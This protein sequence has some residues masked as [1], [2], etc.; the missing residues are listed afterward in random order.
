MATKNIKIG[1]FR[2][3]RLIGKGA[4][5]DV[6]EGIHHNGQRAAIKVVTNA[7]AQRQDIMAQ[8]RNEAHAASKL[9]HPNII[10]L[11]DVGLIDE[12][13]SHASRG[14][15]APS[16]PYLIMELA[17]TFSLKDMMPC[18]HFDQ[19][20]HVARHV[21]RALAHAHARGVIH[22]DIKP[23]NILIE[24]GVER[25]T[26]K[27]SDFGISH[28]L[29]SRED[30]STRD[31]RLQGTP[32]YMAPEQIRG[33]WREQGPWTDLY[34][35]GCV[36]HRMVTGQLLR[37]G[38]LQQV[39]HSHLHDPLPRLRPLFPVPDHFELWLARMLDR[40]IERRYR[41]AA[42]ALA[43]LER[44][45]APLRPLP[46][47]S[48]LGRILEDED[49]PTS[50]SPAAPPHPEGTFGR[51]TSPTQRV[52]DHWQQQD[53]GR[54]SEPLRGIGLGLFG[55]KRSRTV[56]RVPQRDALWDAFKRTVATRRPHM[57]VLEGPSGI[58]KTHL[59]KWLAQRT[60][61]L[62]LSRALRASY[63]L[64][65][66]PLDG[67]PYALAKRY[68]LLGLPKKAIERSLERWMRTHHV[69]QQQ[70][71]GMAPVLTALWSTWSSP[72]DK[73]ATELLSPQQRNAALTQ[74]LTHMPARRAL[75]VHLDNV[76]WATQDLDILRRLLTDESTQVPILILATVD[77]DAAQGSCWE[78]LLEDLHEHPHVQTLD[79]E[80]MHDT[81]I[82]SL[83]RSLIGLEPTLERDIIARSKG[84]PVFTVEL[85]SEL[86]TSDALVQGP[87]GYK[88]RDPMGSLIPRDVEA[89]WLARVEH[90]IDALPGESQDNVWMALE[91]ASVMTGEFEISTWKMAAMQLAISI[92]N[93]LLDHLSH[94]GLLR[95]SNLSAHLSHPL[96]A[97][98]LCGHAR[99]HGRWE[100]LHSACA[101]ALDAQGGQDRRC[102]E[103]WLE[104]NE[105]EQALVPLQ[106]IMEAK[107]HRGMFHDM[108]QL[109]ETHQHILDQ[110]PY[111][112][113]AHTQQDFYRGLLIMETGRRSQAVAHFDKALERAREHGW[114]VMQSLILIQHALICLEAADPEQARDHL[115]QAMEAASHT[116]R[117]DIKVSILR[118]QAHINLTQGH[119]K[120]ALA[121]LKILIE[122]CKEDKTLARA[123]A[124]ALIDQSAVLATMGQHDR[125]DEAIELA[126]QISQEAGGPR[127]IARALTQRGELHRHAGRHQQAISDYEQALHM[128]A[129]SESPRISAPLHL[130]IAL[131]HLD[132]RQTQEAKHHLYASM[133]LAKRLNIQYIMP[134]V[135]LGLLICLMT[136]GRMERCVEL[137]TKIQRDFQDKRLTHPR[138]LRMLMVTAMA[139]AEDRDMLAIHEELSALYE[140]L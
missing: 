124:S 79:I 5:A 132:Q 21:L 7:Q 126:L 104:A 12:A 82:S 10:A 28:A 55:I 129:F 72:P 134:F 78:G 75:V 100:A 9:S 6:W 116:D 33:L 14:A 118:N 11:Y 46:P 49:E 60:A 140:T 133:D 2:L 68:S 109:V 43:D 45:H 65:H 77:S 38:T 64:D 130:N 99:K 119:P 61:E 52:P 53:Q 16:A 39:L 76:Q 47:T 58:G 128:F 31:D 59:A 18:E 137:L 135:H 74:L 13:T 117:R 136:E 32:Y 105:H 112:P 81:A 94:T 37:S 66:G 86:V 85:L 35:L 29:F 88:L 1:P 121:P 40:D 103:H 102:M 101:R 107:L 127:L 93:S 20:T 42:D 34:A 3:T 56:G 27:V 63:H 111:H 110:L 8:F 106:R 50:Q 131:S 17:S 26:F 120:Q 25:N 108:R 95:T 90:A 123:H 67:I 48:A 15:F 96:L 41:F 92:S 98:C 30:D 87:M 114:Y 84:Q 91:L 19:V 80:P 23:S 71:L 83:V 70:A 22:R 97:E 24:H 4:M 113:R 54:P 62:G 125:A 51:Q 138:D 73:A 36:L 139:Q 44:M 57:V 69:P 89:L 122:L 115:D